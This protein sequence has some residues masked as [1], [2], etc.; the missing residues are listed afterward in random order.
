MR[1]L[2]FSVGERFGLQ[3]APDATPADIKRAYYG[4]A[5]ECHPDLAGDEGHNMCVLLN[6][7]YDT[8]SDETDRYNYDVKLH[9]ARADASDGFS[10]RAQ[11]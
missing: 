2:Q 4:M 7:A 1:A 6:S 11:R 8:L 3:V 10:G 5:K 9:K